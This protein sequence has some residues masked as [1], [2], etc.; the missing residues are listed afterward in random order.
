MPHPRIER[1]HSACFN[2]KTVTTVMPDLDLQ[3]SIHIK[4][5]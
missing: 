2:A 4:N 5:M 1:K 3:H